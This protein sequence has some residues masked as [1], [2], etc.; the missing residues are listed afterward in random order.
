MRV[1]VTGATSRLGRGVAEA[2]AARGD[3]VVVMQR[4]ESGL[5][6]AEFDVTEVRADVGDPSDR[7]AVRLAVSGAGAV[8]HL[9]AKVGIVGSAAEFARVNIG[10]TQAVLTAARDA[11][12]ARFVQVSSP[13]VAH[14]GHS[15]VGVGAEPAD[16]SA[17]RGHYSRTKASAEIAA[18]A[19]HCDAM[20]VVAIR[21]HL[22]WGP[23]DTQL[24]G[25][26]IE[27][28]RSGR[29]ALVGNGS[30]LIDTTY[31]DNAV[32]ALV[33]AVDRA[34]LLGGQALVVSNGEPRSVAEL[35]ARI[36]AAAGVPGPKRNVPTS[37]AKF[38]GGV[39]ETAWAL[40]RR[41]SEPPL[42]RFLA[43]QL[44]TAHWFDQ[45]HTREALAWSPRISLD[46][47]F[48]LL[49]ASYR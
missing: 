25:R 34:P 16:P 48:D 32:D 8:V 15:L 22:V 37:M 10:G 44:S 9:A 40:T 23:G 27:R 13:S 42:T 47:G 20:S 29:L 35:V 38:A 7:E 5:V 6:G 24:V 45:R 30:A 12:V 26:I 46:E 31:V 17:A 49:A 21:P 28:A 33:A 14:S 39:V 3:S 1:V 18:L 41:T 36:C 2:L 43:E 19:S 4:R 11:G